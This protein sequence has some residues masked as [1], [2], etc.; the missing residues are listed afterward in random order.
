MLQSMGSQRVRHDLATEQQNKR[1]HKKGRQ[2]G[3]SRGEEDYRNSEVK[4]KNKKLELKKSLQAL[5]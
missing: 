1:Q 4:Y 5:E 2:D 3:W